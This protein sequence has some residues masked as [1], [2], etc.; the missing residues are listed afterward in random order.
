L[1]SSTHPLI[2]SYFEQLSAPTLWQGHDAPGHSSSKLRG[3][4][5]RNELGSPS[6]WREKF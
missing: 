1:I 5:K 4:M 3:G 2:K 6:H